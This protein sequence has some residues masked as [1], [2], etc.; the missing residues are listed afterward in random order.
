VSGGDDYSLSPVGPGE[1]DYFVQF[2]ARRFPGLKGPGDEG[3]VKR[4]A[5]VGADPTGKA[6]DCTGSG[7]ANAACTYHDLNG[8]AGRRYAAVAAATSGL[9]QSI[10]ASDFGPLLTTIASSIGGLIRRFELPRVR[11]DQ[12]VDPASFTVTV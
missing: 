3:L 2:F 12:A 11:V 5:I 7:T 8:H 6:A 4:S 9:S 10:C 1:T